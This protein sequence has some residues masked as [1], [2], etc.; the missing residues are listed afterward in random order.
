M[1]YESL[2]RMRVIAPLKLT[3][4]AITPSAKM[5]AKLAVGHNAVLQPSPPFST[6]PICADMSAAGGLVSTANDLLKLLAA[7]MGYERSPLAPAMATMLSTRRPMPQHGEAQALGWVVIG[8]G[9]DQMIVH[10]GGT[11]GYVS[12][13]AWDPK[14]R[15]GVVVLSNQ[16]AGVSDIARHLLRPNVPL[17]RPTA[18]K[19][20]ETALDS[21]I[22]DTGAGRY[23]GQEEE[24][25]VIVREGDFLTIQLPAS[26]G[27]PKLR[28]RPESRR[29]FFV[30]ELPL[31][32]TFQ[33]DSDG[34]V[35]GLLV[36]PPR[37]QHAIV[38]NRISSD[39]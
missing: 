3:S 22:L 36:Y 15:V 38:A 12:S 5:K 8:E 17:A 7:T 30:A 32:V 31:R 27:L 37:G 11:W 33:T 13:V 28:L 39:R 14:Q 34:H 20:T 23:A 16:M 35:N 10:D 2:L 1:N 29:D 25:F 26:W 19:R 9:D 21:A 6:V 18:T 24:A 4:T